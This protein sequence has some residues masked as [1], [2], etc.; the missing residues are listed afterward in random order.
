MKTQTDPIVILVDDNKIELLLNSRLISHTKISS[1]IVTFD[2]GKDLLADIRN[3]RY[4]GNEYPVIILLDIQMPEMNG[5]E[6]LEEFEKLPKDLKS[7]FRIYILSSTLS[8]ADAERAQKNENVV[9]FYSKP[10]DTDQLKLSL[11]NSMMQ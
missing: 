8:E 1:N 9:E 4:K 10:L 2:N 11:L 6:V 7:R 3:D 5:F